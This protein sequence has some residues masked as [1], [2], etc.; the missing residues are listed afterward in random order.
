VWLLWQILQTTD[1]P[2][3]AHAEAYKITFKVDFMSAGH[4]LSTRNVKVTSFTGDQFYNLVA[5][6]QTFVVPA[7]TDAIAIGVTVTDP[8]TQTTK[9]VATNDVAQV[10]VFGGEGKRR[11]VVFDNQYSALRTRVVEGGNPK[12]G[13]D[14][15]LT[16]T[17]WRADTVV[18]KSSL[19]RQIGTAT[20]YSRFGS[21]EMPIY[22]DIQ[23]EVAYGL[24]FDDVWSGEQP[25]PAT[26]TSRVLPAGRTG[27]EVDVAIPPSA[28][29]LD[30][31][32]HV[33]AILVID[34]SKWG[35]VRS[36]RYNQGD[37]IVLRERWDNLNGEPG[38]NYEL[39][40]DAH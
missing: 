38:H 5:H 25:L 19:D 20:G 23:Y 40:I 15:M 3:L 37:R 28:R 21:F 29:K 22:G 27:F 32:F 36:R 18:D 31:Y 24:A 12:D 14:A 2:D 1:A 34:Y 9:T 13:S 8:Q 11:H 39:P 33:K 16:Y 4:V 35:D 7:K 6:A 17:D 10:P 26:T 30:V